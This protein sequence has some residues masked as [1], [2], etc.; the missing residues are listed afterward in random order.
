MLSYP[1]KNELA[2]NFFKEDLNW[3]INLEKS[4]VIF[5]LWTICRVRGN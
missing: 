4:E 5:L 2:K 3:V 1:N